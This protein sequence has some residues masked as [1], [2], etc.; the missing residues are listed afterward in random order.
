M[1]LD[2]LRVAA[3]IDSLLKRPDEI[4]D[5]FLE[6]RRELELEWRDGEITS[7]R[8]ACERGAAARWRG[9]TQESVASVSGNDES[10]AREAVRGL[11][12]AL[13]RPPLP[14]KQ[15]RDRENAVEDDAFLDGERWTRRLSTL[16]AR[17]APR[18]RF[19]WLL[20]ETVRQVVPSRLSAVSSSRRLISLEGRLTAASRRG[21]EIRGFSF[22]APDAEGVFDELRGALSMA[23]APRDAPVPCPEGENDVVLAD[24]CAA[25]LFHEILSHPLESEVES[26]LTGLEQARV[27]VP[28]LEV[29]DDATRLD[30]FGG[31]ESDDEGVRPKP[32][33][34]LD[35][36]RIAGRLTDRARAA[37]AASNGHARRAGPADPPLV[38]GSNVLVAGGHATAEEMARRLSNGIWIEQFEGGFVELASGQFRLRFPRARRVRRGRL[39]DEIGPGVLAGEILPVLKS[40]ESGLGREVR[41]NRSLGWCSRGGHVVPIQGAAPDVLLRR[42][43]LRSAR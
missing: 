19:R 1:Q 14:V 40:I 17:H 39:S 16:F 34:L 15:G 5:I 31:Y 7:A 26:P 11:Q 9:K 3:W 41:V 8:V 12:M 30:L 32:V 4:A 22:H 37:P 2:P 18:H 33:K 13:G 42:V 28:E 25:V 36:G 20:T 27:A 38:R 6:T 24:G 21:D 10:A 23:A 43:S 35:A 29:R